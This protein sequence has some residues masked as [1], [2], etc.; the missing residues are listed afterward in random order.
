MSLPSDT[1]CN[2]V[3]HMKYRSMYPYYAGQPYYHI[4]PVAGL[5]GRDD[6]QVHQTDSGI[7]KNMESFQHEYESF[8]LKLNDGELSPSNK[9]VMMTTRSSSPAYRRVCIQQDSPQHGHLDVY[10][11]PILHENGLHPRS[12]YDNHKCLPMVMNN[13]TCSCLKSS[14]EFPSGFCM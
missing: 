6:A 1:Y 10:R 5:H 3:L 13:L 9:T 4:H 2:E 14:A 7:T 12:S 11:S 8:M